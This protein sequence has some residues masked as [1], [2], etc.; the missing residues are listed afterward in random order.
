MLDQVP[1]DVDKREGS[2]IYNALAP[3]AGK[4]FEVY[5]S[6]DQVLVLAFPQTSGGGYLEMI[7]EE[8]G[9]KKNYATSSIRH[10]EATGSS[11]QVAEGNRFFVDELYFVAQET[12]NIPGIFQAKS[13]ETGEMTDVYNPEV[14]MPVESID[15]LQSVS[16]IFKHENDVDGIDDETDEALLQRY[17][18]RVSNTPGPGNNSDYVRWAKEITGVGNVLVEPLWK[19]EGTVR[20][21]I[22]TPD[23]DR[24]SQ[25]LIDEVQSVIDPDSKGIGEGKAP[26]GA[27]VAVATADLLF[28]T[29]TIPGLVIEQGYTT[30]QVKDNAKEALKGYLRKINPGGIVRIREAVSK[31]ID[32][33][34]VLDMDDLLINGKRNNLTLD[35]I[36]LVDLGEVN[37]T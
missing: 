4:L 36:Q 13:E 17:W 15:G 3:A 26:S 27:K 33:P 16:I 19:G 22:L 7:V 32:A 9:I 34:G 12:I 5:M 35:I 31:I 20:I 1:D 30:E 24:A 6:L 25:A 10:F 37:Y 23:G 11:G 2:I 29:A 18:E 21:V 28:I 8:E 14:I